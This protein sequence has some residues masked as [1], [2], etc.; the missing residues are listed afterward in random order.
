MT[1]Q[2][3]VSMYHIH[4]SSFERVEIDNR[5]P[6]VTMSIELP[7]W[8]QSNYKEGDPELGIIDLKFYPVYLYELSASEIDYDAMEITEVVLEDGILIF[9]IFD[10]ATCQPHELKIR[11]D[12]VEILNEK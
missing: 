8:L 10:N 11:A 6:S 5:T 2:E 7:L 1:L 4:D 3:F 12:S 9:R